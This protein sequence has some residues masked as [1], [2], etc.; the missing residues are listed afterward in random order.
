VNSQNNVPNGIPKKTIMV[1]RKGMI[2][3]K[4]NEKALE[5]KLKEEANNDLIPLRDVSQYFK[6]YVRDEVVKVLPQTLR[7]E[8]NEG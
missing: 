5:E 1:N 2:T 8:P 7:P 3:E 4:M 6:D